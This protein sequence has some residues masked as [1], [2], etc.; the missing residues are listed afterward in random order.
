M[1]VGAIG[2]VLPAV[3]AIFCLTMTAIADDGVSDPAIDRWITKQ[4]Y[5]MKGVERKQARYTVIGDLDGD[6]RDDVAVLYTIEG[7]GKVRYRLR[8]L[9]AFH[10]G[11]R[12]LQYRAHTMVGG[13]GIRE[14][15]RLTILHRTIEIETLE[16]RPEDALCCPS[17]FATHRYRLNGGRLLRLA[18]WA[19][20]PWRPHGEPWAQTAGVQAAV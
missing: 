9:A 16:Y 13:R 8:Y 11:P 4:A 14:V 7:A 10:R 6:G 19:S 3:V 2:L 15:N 17:R 18:A 1:R 5:R 20:T 12:S